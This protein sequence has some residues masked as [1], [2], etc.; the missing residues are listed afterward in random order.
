MGNNSTGRFSCSA[1]WDKCLRT[2]HNLP[3][4]N[5]LHCKI[6]SLTLRHSAI[7]K[8]TRTCTYMNVMH[9]KLFLSFNQ[10]NKRDTQFTHAPISNQPVSEDGP[11]LSSQTHLQHHVQ[12]LRTAKGF[13]Q[14]GANMNICYI[15]LHTYTVSFQKYNLP[16]L[17]TTLRQ[18]W[19]VALLN[20]PHAYALTA[21]L[22]TIFHTCEVDNHNDCRSFLEEHVLQGHIPS[23]T[24]FLWGGQRTRLQ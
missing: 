22:L 8:S 9:N 13:V 19:K 3:T 15:H 1:R 12:I 18:K 6:S 5:S 2:S 16:F 23:V 17:H 11:Q 10:G 24:K 20:L 7:N 21:P 4:K 14:P